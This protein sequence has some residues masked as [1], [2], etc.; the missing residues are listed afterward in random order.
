LLSE[1]KTRDVIDHDLTDVLARIGNEFLDRLDARRAVDGDFVGEQKSSPKAFIATTGEIPS[2]T[3]GDTG[4]SHKSGEI[5]VIEYA[6]DNLGGVLQW[7]STV[8]PSM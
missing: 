7:V 6:L 3:F 5:K 1:S 4:T 2:P 8:K